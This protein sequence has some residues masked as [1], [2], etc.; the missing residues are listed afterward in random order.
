MTPP[1]TGTDLLVLHTLRCIGF[2]G[3]PRIAAAAGLRE[4]DVESELI[5][6]AVAG[7]VTHMAGEFGGW[8]MT[9]AGKA[10]DAERITAEL[11][12]AGARS[13]ITAVFDSFLVLNPELLDL[14]AAWQLRSIDGV[15]TANDHNDPSYDA[16]VLDRFTEFHQRAAVV[17]AELSAALPRFDRYRARLAEALAR[18]TS[19]DRA[20]VTDNTASYHCVWAELHEDLLAT[21]G[22][23]R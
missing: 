16:R 11:E 2:A 21:L 18:A 19:G 7:L 15:M 8:G 20:Y 23:P 10:A 9:D 4:S 13:A 12:S 1:A 5:D 14:C 22:I 3:L 6:L 17:C